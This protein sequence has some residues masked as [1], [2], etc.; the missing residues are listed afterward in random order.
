MS[1]R[2]LRGTETGYRMEQ[3]VADYLRVNPDFFVRHPNLASQLEIPHAC[4]DAV[5]LIEYQ[6]TVLKAQVQQLRRKLKE[7]I[8]NARNNEDLNNRFQRLTLALIDCRSL[9]QAFA[10]LNEALGESLQADHVAI[11]LFAAPRCPEDQGLGEFLGEDEA[12]RAVF[13]NVLQADNPVCGRLKREQLE[14]LFG[15]QAKRIGSGV[16]MPLGVAERFGL[17]AIA[18]EDK[19]RFHPGMGTA[20]LRQLGE[21][22]AHVI[23]PHLATS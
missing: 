21:V 15:E 10:T 11:R 16:L 8:T 3:Q 4:G 1:M 12:V 17:I 6:I 14:I 18:S 19:A 9:G 2:K 5:S 13:R 7:L 22:A 20:L 23:Q